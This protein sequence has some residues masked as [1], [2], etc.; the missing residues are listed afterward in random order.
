MSGNKTARHRA[1]LKAKYRKA[2][3]RKGRLLKLKKAGGRLQSTPRGK[4]RKASVLG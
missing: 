2:R 4:G 1:A 3:A